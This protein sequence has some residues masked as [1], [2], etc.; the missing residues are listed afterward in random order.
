[1][2]SHRKPLGGNV[3]KQVD[4]DA[5]RRLI[6]DAVLRIAVAEGL[7]SVSLRGVAAAAGVSMGS[8]QHYFGTKEEMLVFAIDHQDRLREQ[9]IAAELGTSWS[10]PREFVRTVLSAVLPT[11]ERSRAEWLAGIA[12]FIRAM[13]VPRIAA[14]LNEGVPKVVELIA[15]QLRL[16]VAVGELESADDLDLREEAILLWSVVDSQ[17]TALVLGQRSPAQAVATL[18]YQLD[19]LFSTG[20]GGA[21]TP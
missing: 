14:I 6:A 20:R 5:R 1:M 12:F 16:A 10:G 3:P 11:D 21:P 2:Q 19:R 15:D 17:S 7:E 4:H 9:R 18:D 13:R 8:I